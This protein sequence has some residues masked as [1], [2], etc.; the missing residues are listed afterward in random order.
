MVAQSSDDYLF[1]FISK[2][3]QYL[4]QQ[5]TFQ[6]KGINLKSSYFFLS[7]DDDKLNLISVLLLK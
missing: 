3:F 2:D 1:Q 7:I 5:K 6:Y 4:T